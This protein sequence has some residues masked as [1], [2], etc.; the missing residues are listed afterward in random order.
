VESIKIEK[1]HLLLVE[2]K[3]EKGFFE[4]L[5]KHLQ[6]GDL[7]IID[8]QG[9]DNIRDKLKAVIK[10]PAF[11]MVT[12]LGVVRDADNSYDTAFQSI[13]QAIKDAGLPV[14][15]NHLLT[16]DQ[17]P[18][19][20]VW[21]M[22]GKGRTGM[23]EDLC[24]EAVSGDPACLCVEQYFDCLKNQINR[25]PRE[26]LK[27]KLQV[28]LASK[29]EVNLRLGEAALKGY[30]PWDSEAFKDVRDFLSTVSKDT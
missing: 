23:L 10:S 16:G 24:L 18:R 2:G 6:I 9:K 5:S 1:R 15:P 3:D 7:Q 21:I 22:P 28:F 27:A 29:P 30:F 17:K 26:L 13:S 19:V 11:S 14:S 25:P 8:C 20:S 12:S 4:D